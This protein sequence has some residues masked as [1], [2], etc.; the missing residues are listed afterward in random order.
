MKLFSNELFQN[1]NSC[2]II[3]TYQTRKGENNRGVDTENAFD[4][5]LDS[6]LCQAGT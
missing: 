6:W 3:N 5:Y 4:T 2:D 1:W